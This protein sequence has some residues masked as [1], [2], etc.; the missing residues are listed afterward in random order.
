M[1]KRSVE[2]RW[3]TWKYFIECSCLL[4]SWYIECTLGLPMQHLQHFDIVPSVSFDFKGNAHIFVWSAYRIVLDELD[5]APRRYTQRC[6]QSLWILGSHCILETRENV[7]SLARMHS[8]H[9]VD[10]NHC[11]RG[12]IGV[13][14]RRR[15][16]REALN[17]YNVL[18]WL[19]AVQLERATEV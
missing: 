13:R 11:L 10:G 1:K 2:T 15:R 4:Y 9:R 14:R 19:V 18:F 6:D 3:F 16:R 8:K 12:F 5:S 17:G 7:F